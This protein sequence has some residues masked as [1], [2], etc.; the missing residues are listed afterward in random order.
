[1]FKK[2]HEMNA[3]IIIGCYLNKFI[4]QLV[5]IKLAWMLFGKLRYKSLNGARESKFEILG[6]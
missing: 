2:P 6:M 1:M 5:Y 3:P 4:L